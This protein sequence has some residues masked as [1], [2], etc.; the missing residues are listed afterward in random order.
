MKGWLGSVVWPLMLMQSLRS[1]YRHGTVMISFLGCLKGAEY[2]L[3]GQHID[4]GY[5]R[6]LKV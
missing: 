1:S 2:L 6:R 3:Y 4:W 5:N